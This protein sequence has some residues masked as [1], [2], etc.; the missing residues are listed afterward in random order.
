MTTREAEDVAINGIGG[1]TEPARGVIVRP[2]EPTEMDVIGGGGCTRLAAHNFDG[3]PERQM[4]LEMAATGPDAASG[5]DLVGTTLD[6][7]YWYAHRVSIEGE[8]G[9]VMEAP[10]VVLIQPDGSA[11]KFVSDGIFDALRMIVKYYG[12]RPFNPPLRMQIKEVKTRRGRKML[13]LSPVLDK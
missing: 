11:V 1:A 7:V 10:R 3:P 2:D 12:R 5:S 13:T 4:L 6:V 9:E 8:N